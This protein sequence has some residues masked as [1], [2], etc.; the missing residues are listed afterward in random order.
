MIASIVF[1]GAIGMEGAIVESVDDGASGLVG[2]LGD[3]LMYGIDIG[4][5]DDASGYAALVGYDDDSVS[6][7]S[8]R[9]Q[10]MG[11]PSVEAD[12]RNISGIAEGFD[13]GVVA[14]KENGSIHSGKS[15][16]TKGLEVQ[17]WEK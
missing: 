7:E 14:I 15:I 12:A 13:D 17:D 4:F 9:C 1:Y 5:G 16:V 3:S 2:E 8:Q 6:E 11:G 10:C